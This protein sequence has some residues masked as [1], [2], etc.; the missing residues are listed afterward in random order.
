MLMVVK[1]CRIFEASRAG[2]SE[3]RCDTI[4]A[5]FRVGDGHMELL[6]VYG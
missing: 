6:Q 5:V 2:R 1:I 4:I 3:Y